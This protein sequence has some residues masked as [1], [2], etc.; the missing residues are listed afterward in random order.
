MDPAWISTDYWF[1]HIHTNIYKNK[2]IDECATEKN[3][4]SANAVYNNIKGSYNCKCKPGYS[5]D[6]RTCKGICAMI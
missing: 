6:G 3:R 1:D 4:C 2:D 5:G